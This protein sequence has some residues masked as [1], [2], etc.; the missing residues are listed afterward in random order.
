M[1]KLAAT[2]VSSVLLLPNFAHSGPCD[3][4]ITHGLRNISISESDA[5]LRSL[6]ANR[7]CSFDRTS[8]TDQQMAGLEVEVFGYG[9][10]EGD[11][12]RS[13]SEERVKSWCD[14]RDAAF[15]TNVR[16]SAQAE[17]FY[18][19]AV[20]AWETCL[21]L[22]NRD[23]KITPIISA[24]RRT[25]DIGIVY[26][27]LDSPDA[28]LKGVK[29]EGFT[30]TLEN[31]DQPGEKVVYPV[32]LGKATFNI[33]CTR[34]NAKEVERGGELYEV[35]PRGVISIHTAS[36]PFQL[37]FAE[38]FNPSLPAEVARQIRQDVVDNS[39]PIGA[40]VWSSFASEVFLEKL[41]EKSQRARYALADGSPIPSGSKLESILGAGLLPDLTPL[42][43]AGL[44][45]AD[46]TIATNISSGEQISSKFNS[47][48]SVDKWTYSFSLRDIEGQAYSPNEY[49]QDVDQFQIYEVNGALI[50]QGRTWNRKW[51][52]WGAWK[53]GQANLFALGWTQ[54]K[55]YPYIRVD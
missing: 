17:S 45:A 10:G 28:N 40:I 5:A 46:G 37:F 21:K 53:G 33:S 55:L 7:A 36:E 4:I 52:V 8:L 32:A 39:V 14:S 51:N 24:D 3:S 34:D 29:A 47:A 41:L 6:K 48:P 16:S 27:G 38:E 26:D 22:N 25:V 9:Q 2:A 31:L 49:E 19:G 54:L 1:K 35:V 43:G 30:C 23:F 50:A 20:S 18:Q 11:Y 12:S 42:T 44:L 13:K 15:A